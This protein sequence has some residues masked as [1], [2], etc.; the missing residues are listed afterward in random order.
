MAVTTHGGTMPGGVTP[1]CDDCGV[2]L[3]WDISRTEYLEAR[4]FWDA[5]R[6][7]GCSPIKQSAHGW[8]LI[9]GREAL[10]ADVEALIAAYEEANP[11]I[12]NDPSSRG[13]ID[14]ARDFAAV[15]E[16]DAIPA[17]VVEIAR[18]RGT[19]HH[20]VVVGDFT[21]DWHAGIHDE[22][23]PAPLVYRTTHGWPVEPSTT[24]QLLER[25]SGLDPEDLQALIAEAI[26]RR[27]AD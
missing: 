17:T 16:A 3:C 18:V 7:R 9:N 21:I 19:P 25:L 5:W 6:C 14:T 24:A 26:G 2:S 15:L 20:G 10:P 11:G 4:P 27:R 22:D 8:R 13:S 12:V 23:A 1:T